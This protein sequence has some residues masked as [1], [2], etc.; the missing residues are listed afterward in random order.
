MQLSECLT[1]EIN[2][3]IDEEQFRPQRFWVRKR[4][5][6]KETNLKVSPS[7]RLIVVCI[8]KYTQKKQNKFSQRLYCRR[9]RITYISNRVLK[10]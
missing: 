8:S 6:R 5:R 7:D 10:L 3:L 1:E 2:N 4:I 9:C